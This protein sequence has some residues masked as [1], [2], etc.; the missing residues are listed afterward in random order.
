MNYVIAFACSE[1]ITIAYINCVFRII[2]HTA[3]LLLP[4]Y[5]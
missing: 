2:S 5:G 3:A 4:Q 1:D